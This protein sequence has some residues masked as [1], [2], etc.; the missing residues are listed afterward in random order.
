[1]NRN[2]NDYLIPLSLAEGRL[3][4]GKLLYHAA[5]EIPSGGMW[6]RTSLDDLAELEEQGLIR[7][8]SR[9]NSRHRRVEKTVILLPDGYDACEKVLDSDDYMRFAEKEAEM[10]TIAGTFEEGMEVNCEWT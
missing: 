2:Q 1:M 3:P 7:I 4:L 5:D 8:A 6:S 9:H 10:E